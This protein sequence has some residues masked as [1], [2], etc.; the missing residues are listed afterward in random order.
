MT[1]IHNLINNPIKVSTKE[2]LQLYWNAL[3][4]TGAPNKM[5]TPPPHS[6][7][8]KSGADEMQA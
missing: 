8:I 2:H 5:P 1:K 4:C 7:I 6:S 3:D